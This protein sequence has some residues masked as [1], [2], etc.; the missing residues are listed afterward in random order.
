MANFMRMHLESNLKQLPVALAK[1]EIKSGKRIAPSPPLATGMD[2]P[3][4]GGEDAVAAK[5]KRT[6]INL[7]AMG[8]VHIDSYLGTYIS[9]SGNSTGRAALFVQIIQAAGALS[10]ELG[11]EN[12][13][14]K[15][16]SDRLHN[17]LKA[18]NAKDKAAAA[19]AEAATE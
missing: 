3:F 13:T 11:S 4:D 16:V 9:L 1:L 15:V 19:A 12:W 17:A 5:A 7:T 8:R 14:P 18:K 10:Q 6:R 2:S